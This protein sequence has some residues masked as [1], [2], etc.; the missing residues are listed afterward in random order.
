MTVQDHLQRALSS[1]A[2]G[3]IALHAAGR[4]DTGV[5]AQA[6]MAHFETDVVRPLQAW[7]RGVN[8][9]LP[10]AIAVRWAQAVSDGFHAR[11][12]ARA[13][14]YRYLLHNHPVRPALQ[15][16]RVGWYHRPLDAT[17]MQAAAQLLLGEQD[18]SSFRASECQ[19]KS[20]IKTLHQ[21]D[22]RR[23]GEYVVF[24]FAASGF[25][26]HMVRNL[27]GALLWV[28]YGRK[29]PVWMGEVLAARCREAAAPTFMPDGLYFTGVDYGPEWSLPN[30][31]RI[32][33]PLQTLLP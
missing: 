19:A 15:R 28:G 23:Y 22:V 8:A 4:T 10:G 18:F 9:H 7:V 11:F 32:I 31:G 1:I 21:A 29:P 3:P 14:R 26:H 20:P 17:A 24:E 30:G 6:Q 25:L 2:G 33:A 13:R 5:H 16:G 27:V 12:S